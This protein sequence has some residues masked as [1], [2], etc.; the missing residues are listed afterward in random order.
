M[1]TSA[2]AICA[3]V[4]GSSVERRQARH[5]RDGR[6][7]LAG[8]AAHVHSPLGGQGMNTGI[9][10]AIN[11][12]WKLAAPSAAAAPPWLLDSYER[13]RH[14]VGASVL[15]LTD[16]FNQLV[17]GRSAVR[18]ALRRVRHQHPSCGLPRSRRLIGERLSGIGIGYP[19]SRGDDG[20]VGARMPDIECDGTRLYELLR[21]GRF[22]LVTAAHVAVRSAR[23]RA[24]RR[25]QFG[26]AG[27]RAGPPGRIHRVGERTAAHDCRVIGGH[28]SLVRPPARRVISP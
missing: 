16:A 22:V 26:P 28:R 21:E 15:K 8:D 9:G 4:R 27:R 1:R 14:P 12:G 24:C 13:E 19:R 3:G 17:L 11:L 6:V 2:W 10:D 25:R 7:F 23:H 18:R 5:Y 20:M